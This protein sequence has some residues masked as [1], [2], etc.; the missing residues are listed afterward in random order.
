MQ[1]KHCIAKQ[2]KKWFRALKSPYV[3]T[4]IVVW[5]AF[6]IAGFCALCLFISLTSIA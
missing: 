3:S 6:A 2:D 1:H 5:L 4:R